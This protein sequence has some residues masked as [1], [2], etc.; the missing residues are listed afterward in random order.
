MNIKEIKA[1]AD[2]LMTKV[3][4]QRKSLTDKIS[5]SE[6]QLEASTEQ[7]NEAYTSQNDKLYHSAQDSIRT[8]KDSIELFTRQLSE[9]DGKSHITKEEYEQYKA[10]IF[11][12]LDNLVETSE[13]HLVALIDEIV[14][15]V[16]NVRSAVT[17]A[18]ELLNQ[19]QIR[20]YHDPKYYGKPEPIRHSAEDKYK[21]LGHGYLVDYLTNL[22]FYKD[23][24]QIEAEPAKMWG[25]K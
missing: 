19:L 4:E 10:D 6:K 11:A 13:A 3:N 20:L 8:A 9:L 22:Q 25:A 12:E 15:S 2:K 5:A 14:A 16:Y 21:N 1:V 23:A 17:D 18:N 7:A 24:K